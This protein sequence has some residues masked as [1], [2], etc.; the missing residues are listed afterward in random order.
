MTNLFLSLLEISLPVSGLIVLLLLLT[1]LFE[2]RYAARWK[3]WVW[4]VLALRLL[5]PFGG[6]SGISPAE[7]WAQR[8]ATGLSESMQTVPEPPAGG[9]VRG[10]VTVELPAQ[11]TAPIAVSPEETG[12][13]LSWLDIIAC[14]W[15]SGSVWMM[16]VP[17]AGY[18]LF[19]YG[20]RKKG[21]AVKDEKVLCLLQK[22]KDELHIRGTVSVIEYSKA[23][24]P[25]L[26][27]FSGPVIVMPKEQYSAEELYFI[28]KHELIHLKRGDL[29]CKLLFE[30]VRAV[31][32][33]NPLVWVMQKAAAVDMEL[34]CDERVIRGSDYA[35][36]KAYTEALFAALHKRNAKK[37]ALSTNFYGGKQIMKKRFENILAKTGKKN[38]AAVLACAVVL[39][40]SVGTLV[41]CSVTPGGAAAASAPSA[42][43]SPAAVSGPSDAGN[44]QAENLQSES[45]LQGTSDAAPMNAAFVPG[46]GCSDP[47]C[48]DAAHHHDCP[49]GCADYEHYHTCALDCTEASHHHSTAASGTSGHHSGHHADAHH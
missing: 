16:C 19:Q 13:S 25:M 43:S 34:S 1:P 20:L 3:Y 9:T 6:N 18:L 29:Y 31:H 38:G 28:L 40:V 49:A 7:P 33:W 23:V 12:N 15:V 11:M 30:V 27:G 2:K 22:L 5:I 37:V 26:T 48:T 46:M 21:S 45:P 47:A 35:Q 41:G 14:V 42:A 10:R 36:R 17:L 4:I 32:W 44:M 8:E 39:A 24:S